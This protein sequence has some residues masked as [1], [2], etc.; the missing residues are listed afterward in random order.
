MPKR[1]RATIGTQKH[2]IE[3]EDIGVTEWQYDNGAIVRYASTTNCPMGAWYAKIEI[4]G[5]EGMLV[6]TTGGPEGNHT[7]YGKNDEWTE[8]CPFDVKTALAAGKRPFR[9]LPAYGR[10]PGHL[11]RIQPEIPR[12]SGRGV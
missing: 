8:E 5:T 4:I 6:Y 12:D 7:W 3:A 2:Q 10:A 1:V 9:L 11:R